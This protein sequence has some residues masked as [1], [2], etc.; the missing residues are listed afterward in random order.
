[1]LTGYKAMKLAIVAYIVPFTFVYSPTLLLINP[2]MFYTT[3]VFFFTFL[4]TISLSAGIERYCFTELTYFE[5]LLIYDRRRLNV[6]A[7]FTDYDYRD[8]YCLRR[9]P[10]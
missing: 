10:A 6:L 8:T 9:G 4:G 2:D 7:G 5:T 3:I 1:M